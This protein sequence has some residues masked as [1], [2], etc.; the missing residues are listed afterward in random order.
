MPTA[1]YY[2]TNIKLDPIT[3]PPCQGNNYPSLIQQAA[4]EDPSPQQSDV[5]KPGKTRLYPS[6]IA[7]NQIPVLDLTN[8]TITSE[9]DLQTAFESLNLCPT[10][11][12]DS[13][14]GR[15][16]STTK[17]DPSGLHIRQ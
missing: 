7:E 13:S 9:V 15:E 11:K 4:A 16:K 10:R 12:E 14:H 8:S 17:G 6:L 2:F 1:D 3:I 5:L